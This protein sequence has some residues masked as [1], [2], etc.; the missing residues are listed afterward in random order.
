MKNQHIPQYCGSCW[1]HGPTSSL[2]D[3]INIQRGN[4]F[5]R[6]TL[7]PQVIL[8]VHGGGNCFGGNPGG[9][10]DFIHNYGIGSDSCHN[11]NATSISA[12]DASNT[13]P[14]IRECETC[15]ENGCQ[16]VQN[17]DKW[18]VSEFGAVAGADN[19]KA[20]IY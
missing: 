8:N 2:S 9:V 5:P 4:V 20:E 1:A 17:F 16:A 10:Y 11:Y 6:V 14:A 3:R 19:M 15:N 7:S 12:D 18:Y 13:F